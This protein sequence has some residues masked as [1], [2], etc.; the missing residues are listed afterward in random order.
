M[1]NKPE[2]T[3][4]AGVISATVWQNAA[5]SK[6]GEDVVFKTI[7]LKRSYKDKDEKWQSTSSFRINDLP[8]VELV[9]KK[10]YEHI[11]MSN[12]EASDKEALIEEVI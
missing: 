10:A 3:F 5:K 1:E 12:A 6:N 9:A 11:M 8:K 2:K 7:S 4:R